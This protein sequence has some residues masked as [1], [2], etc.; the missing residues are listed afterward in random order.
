M[1]GHDRDKASSNMRGGRIDGRSYQNVTLRGSYDFDW[2]KAEDWR[3]WAP[4]VVKR[5]IWQSA[6]R[7]AM[8]NPGR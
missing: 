3:G 5:V 6:F 7:D 1:T 2:Q 8:P 4:G